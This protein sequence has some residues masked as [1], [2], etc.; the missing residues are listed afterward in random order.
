MGKERERQK[1]FSKASEERYEQWERSGK[2]FNG[3]S[4]KMDIYIDGLHPPQRKK[5]KG[6]ST[7]KR[8]K[9]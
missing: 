1:D 9:N 6:V 5:P 3:R 8:K 4:T 2:S 7:E